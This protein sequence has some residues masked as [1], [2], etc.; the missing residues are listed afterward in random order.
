MKIHVKRVARKA[1]CLVEMPI[2]LV[3]VLAMMRVIGEK[4]EVGVFPVW[5]GDNLVTQESRHVSFLRWWTKLD[6][7]V[8]IAL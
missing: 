8:F 3:L 1:S 4:V 2:E 6:L 5:L 7:R